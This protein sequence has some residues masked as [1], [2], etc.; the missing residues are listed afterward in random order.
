MTEI[1]GVGRQVHEMAIIRYV[2][3]TLLL[4]TAVILHVGEWA[5]FIRVQSIVLSWSEKRVRRKKE[6]KTS[7]VFLPSARR[8]FFK[9][10]FNP[11]L[12]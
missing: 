12:G 8:P 11:F 2:A 3:A 1:P 9:Y 7:A 6:R 4:W 10:I 5:Y